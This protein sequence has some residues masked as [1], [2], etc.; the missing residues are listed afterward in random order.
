MWTCTRDDEDV[1][2]LFFFLFFACAIL[3]DH[4]GGQR[5]P[6]EG[7]GEHVDG[8]TGRG[9]EGSR[10][11]P[12]RGHGPYGGGTGVV[13]CGQEGCVASTGE[14]A[15][16]EDTREDR[17]ASLRLADAND[18]WTTAMHMSFRSF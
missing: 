14:E 7:V 5:V 18:A 4:E 9:E 16:E 10:K 12:A 8:F 3:R 2:V 6:E 15:T 13:E 17:V 11:V 1:V